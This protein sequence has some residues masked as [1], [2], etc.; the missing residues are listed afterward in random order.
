MYLLLN[1]FLIIDINYIFYRIP[2][3]IL[4]LLRFY[5]VNMI[6]NCIVTYMRLI[7]SSMFNKFIICIWYLNWLIVSMLNCL[8]ISHRFSYFDRVSYCCILGFY[9]L[10]FIRNLFMSYNRFIISIR[11]L[12]RNMFY[13]CLRLRGP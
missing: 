2:Y 6:N 7:F 12:D 8:I 9:V 11:F 1:S 5:C 10:S 3:L 4:N 13:P